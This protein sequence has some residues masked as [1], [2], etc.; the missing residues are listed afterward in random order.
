[1]QIKARVNVNGKPTVLDVETGFVSFEMRGVID[2]LKHRTDK[3]SNVWQQ[4]ILNGDRM[5]LPALLDVEDATLPALLDAVEKDE[6][7]LRGPVI[8]NSHERVTR[9]MNHTTGRFEFV[10]QTAK[11]LDI[12]DRKI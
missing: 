2:H 12:G 6:V 11:S 10:T 9:R 4:T 5:N 8:R 3:N 7:R 1:M